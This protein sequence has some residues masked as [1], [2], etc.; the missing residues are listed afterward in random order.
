MNSTTSGEP[1]VCDLCGIKFFAR[2]HPVDTVA[3]WHSVVAHQ[4]LGD[5]ALSVL[6]DWE[7]EIWL[8]WDNP[9]AQKTV[10]RND[11]ALIPFLSESTL[12]S[13]GASL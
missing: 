3:G 12:K 13:L 1:I 9:S 5:R 8:A 4:E 10:N 2:E 11:K 6:W 7:A